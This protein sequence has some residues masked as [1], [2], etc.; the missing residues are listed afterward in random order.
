ML[1]KRGS[2]DWNKNNVRCENIKGRIRLHVKRIS[3]R[4]LLLNEFGIKQD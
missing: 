3:F 4:G 1:L 2:E